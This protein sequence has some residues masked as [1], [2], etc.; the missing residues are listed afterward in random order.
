MQRSQRRRAPAATTFA[1]TFP[2]P[3]LPGRLQLT[4]DVEEADLRSRLEQLLSDL[5]LPVPRE[6]RCR[7]GESQARSGGS[8]AMRS[9]LLNPDDCNASLMPLTRLSSKLARLITG[10][11]AWVTLAGG[12]AAAGAAMAAGEVGGWAGDEGRPSVRA[13]AILQRCERGNK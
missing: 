6:W 1:S 10:A 5:V 9:C 13:A 11:L 12:G 3:S 4:G 2:P 7:A 8:A